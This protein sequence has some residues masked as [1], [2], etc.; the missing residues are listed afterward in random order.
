MRAFTSA[1]HPATG[2]P[3]RGLA[4]NL[5][6]LLSVRAQESVLVKRTISFATVVA[7]LLLTGC[8]RSPFGQDREP[9]GPRYGPASGAAMAFIRANDIPLL[10]WSDQPLLRGSVEFFEVRYGQ[11]HDCPSGCFYSSAYGMRNGE[12]IG[13]IHLD[14]AGDGFNPAPAMRFDVVAADTALF[15]DGLWMA[16]DA[17]ENWLLRT[18]LAPLLASDVDTPIEVLRRLAAG[19]VADSPVASH[20]LAY[21][22]VRHPIAQGDCAV[23]SDLAHLPV[24]QGDPYQAERETALVYY[25]SL[26]CSSGVP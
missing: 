10:R 6:S 19:L 4:D 26:G 23:L 22:L 17:V 24:L 3:P 14:D 16:V 8:S 11:P 9:A 25:D 7:V 12:R 21:L 5:S 1:I 20:Y 13:W 18:A 2:P 15:A